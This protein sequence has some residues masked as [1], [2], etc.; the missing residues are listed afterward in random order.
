[1]SSIGGLPASLEQRSEFVTRL[2]RGCEW[3]RHYYTGS[4]VTGSANRGGQ[5]H[6]MRAATHFTRKHHINTAC[7]SNRHIVKVESVETCV[8]R[9]FR[10]WQCRQPGPLRSGR[11][12]WR[13]QMAQ[14]SL[15]SRRLRHGLENR[16]VHSSLSALT[17]HFLW[18]NSGLM[19][20]AAFSWLG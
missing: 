4:A 19:P 1:M 15:W 13:Q 10:P 16:Y 7:A 17:S 3:H 9:K 14:R 12:N 6:A 11:T 2:K 5:R 20:P 18:R 8:V